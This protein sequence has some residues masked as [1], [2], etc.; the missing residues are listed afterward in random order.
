MPI[1]LAGDDDAYMFSLYATL[2]ILGIENVLRCSSLGGIIRVVACEAPALLFYDFNSW[3][4]DLHW[5]Y[6]LKHNDPDS[7][8]LVIS[9]H[10]SG[11]G[12]VSKHVQ[13][14]IIFDIVKKPVDE[15]VLL[16][17]IIRARTHRE[18]LGAFQKSRLSL[19]YSSKSNVMSS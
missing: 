2:K 8:P 9:V 17:K 19:D 13:D 5:L 4:D 3:E 6:Q 12:N 10:S 11:T 14:G 16:T 7:D 1:L 18:L 15:D